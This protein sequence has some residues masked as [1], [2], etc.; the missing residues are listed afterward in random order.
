MAVDERIA[1][2][3]MLPGRARIA[4]LTL[5]LRAVEREAATALE[6]EAGWDLDTAITQLRGRLESLIEARRRELAE[7]LR[8]ERDH[9]DAV[10]AA[11]EAEATLIVERA[12]AAAAEADILFAAAISAVDRNEDLVAWSFDDDHAS[13]E[14]VE[15]DDA[16]HAIA[17]PDADAVD[18][19]IG[20]VDIAGDPVVAEEGPTPD[21]PLVIL[22]VAPLDVEAEPFVA[23][24]SIDAADGSAW[25]VTPTPAAEITLEMDATS[26]AEAQAD[27]LIAH[28]AEPVQRAV[29]TV[30]GATV[31][32]EIDSE[33]F[34]RAF[35]IAF[36][37]ALAEQQMLVP[38]RR[39][40]PVESAPR[41][42]FW[43]HAWHADVVLSGVAIAIVL[44]VLVAWTT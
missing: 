8:S 9:A 6:H 1:A 44:A 3:D 33:S 14:V 20:D 12:H 2:A 4:M 15:D 38:A 40:V 26:P 37:T 10:V 36:A 19:P 16:T 35:A 13:A 31:R 23:D 29:E 28:P 25:S 18:V 7:D 17:G 34:S 41:R 30:S 43:A 21:E 22:A 27:D 32:F 42:S 5:Q 39:Y 24:G 11:A